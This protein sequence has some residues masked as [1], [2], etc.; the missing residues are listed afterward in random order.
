MSKT[1]IPIF[2]RFFI[3]IAFFYSWDDERVCLLDFFVICQVDFHPG[4]SLILV[5]RTETIIC[6]NRNQSSAW[7]A[8]LL[9]WHDFCDLLSLT[10]G[11]LYGD[12]FSGLHCVAVRNSP[13]WYWARMGR[14][15]RCAETNLEPVA[16]VCLVPCVTTALRLGSFPSSITRY[17]INLSM[18]KSISAVEANSSLS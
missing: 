11:D 16:C 7:A 5:T 14:K 17:S 13:C 3:K 6:P 1:V 18:L 8:M 12:L 2:M 10:S 9:F 4:C 15:S